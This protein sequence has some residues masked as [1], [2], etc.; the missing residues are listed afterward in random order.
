[1]EEYVL[2][3]I[4]ENEK[5]FTKDD[6]SV[7]YKNINIIVNIYDLATVSAVNQLKGRSI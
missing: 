2:N 5:M 1:M 6:L 4:K 3:I 7:I